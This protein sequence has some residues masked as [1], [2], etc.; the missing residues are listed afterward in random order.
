MPL[1]ETSLPTPCGKSYTIYASR[2]SPSIT[3]QNPAFRS[4]CMAESKVDSRFYGTQEG[5]LNSCSF[6]LLESPASRVQLFVGHTR[7]IISLTLGKFE[8][9]ST[10]PCTKRFREMA[11]VW[12]ST[13]L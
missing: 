2:A 9:I 7:R 11:L 12:Q 10:R 4:I 6:L 13:R 1:K 8:L 3:T 5:A